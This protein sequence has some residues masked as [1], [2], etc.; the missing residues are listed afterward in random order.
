M[1]K[2]RPSGPTQKSLAPTKDKWAQFNEGKSA[3]ERG[4]DTAWEKLRANYIAEEPL[5]ELCLKKNP[6]QV[7]SAEQ[8]DHIIPFKGIHDPLRLNWDNLQSVCVPCHR[9]KEARYR[10]NRNASKKKQ[11]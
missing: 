2:Y 6:V 9:A 10:K 4:Y 3:R 1:K 11:R 7:S 8:V 5:C